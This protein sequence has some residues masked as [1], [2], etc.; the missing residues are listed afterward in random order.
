MYPSTR[1]LGDKELVL[2]GRT[3]DECQEACIS[4]VTPGDSFGGTCASFN[5]NYATGQ[6]ELS[7]TSAVGQP[8]LTEMIGDIFYYQRDCAE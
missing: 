1:L 4:P 5:F 6:C 8:T 3:H 2:D 7:L